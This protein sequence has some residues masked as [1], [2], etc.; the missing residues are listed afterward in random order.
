MLRITSIALSL[1]AVA[2]SHAQVPPASDAAAST[3]Q[4]A[5]PKQLDTFRG[6][7][8]LFGAQRL[9]DVPPASESAAGRSGVLAMRPDGTGLEVIVEPK[10]GEWIGAGRISPD[11]RRL[12]FNANP[13]ATKQSDIWLATLDG[14][15]QKL[16]DN[17]R[18][19]AWSPDSTKLLCVRGGHNDWESF[20][21]DVETKQ[22]QRLAIPK[23]DFVEDWSPDGKLLAVVQA[24]ADKV[25]KHPEK[26]TYPLRHLYLWTIDQAR[27]EPFTSGTMQ[28]NLHSRFSPDAKRIAYDQRRYLEDRTLR[29]SIMVRDTDAKGEKEIVHLDKL[30]EAGGYELFRYSASP[31]WSPDGKSLVSLVIRRKWE[32]TGGPDQEMVNKTT[33]ALLIA[34]AEMGVEEQIDLDEK[35]IVFVASVDWR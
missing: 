9:R 17:A 27:P 11:G 20:I 4:A 28:D 5:R 35:G 8:L 18:V 25:F 23:S 1:V 6:M 31:C 13:A 16:A 21:L 10:T 24:N 32:P 33:M 26:G 3:T 34:S 15:R 14:Q 19:V 22:E 29:H 12:A 30:R 7:I 2:L